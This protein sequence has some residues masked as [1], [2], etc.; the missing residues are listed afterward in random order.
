M[1][2]G[3]FRSRRTSSS[4]VRCRGTERR[5]LDDT[6]AA[7]RRETVDI[8]CWAD[9]GRTRRAPGLDAFRL[10][11]LFDRSAD[12]ATVRPGVPGV[13]RG[14]R[15]RNRSG[16]AAKRCRVEAALIKQPWARPLTIRITY[17]RLTAGEAKL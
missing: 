13:G 1:N 17:I 9:A 14:S 6:R 12:V 5:G 10:T 2:S 16:I 7:I 4:S 3:R 11:I 15:K 8:K